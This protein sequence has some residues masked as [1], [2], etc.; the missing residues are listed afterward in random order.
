MLFVAGIV[1]LPVVQDHYGRGA[2]TE[3]GGFR[4]RPSFSFST[5]ARITGKWIFSDQKPD[6]DSPAGVWADLLQFENILAA[7]GGLLMDLLGL[8]ESAW[9][10]LRRRVGG[11]WA[12]TDRKT[13]RRRIGTRDRDIGFADKI[14]PIFPNGRDEPRRHSIPPS[15][16]AE[17]HASPGPAL[18]SRCA[19]RL[20]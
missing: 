3:P 5:T 20:W 15:A 10:T 16:P 9:A 6:L 12:I 13:D 11:R 7:F 19:T 4:A 1:V 2:E 14:P 17:E 8:R 18:M